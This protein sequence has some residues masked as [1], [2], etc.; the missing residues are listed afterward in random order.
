MRRKPA[1]ISKIYLVFVHRSTPPHR[2]VLGCGR[3]S[4]PRPQHRA[5][6]AAENLPNCALS[7]DWR[8]AG[9]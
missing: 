7:A 5:G 2:V 9:L 8:L 6:D 3:E 4:S 1:E